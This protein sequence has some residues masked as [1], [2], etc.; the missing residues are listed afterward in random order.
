MDIYIVEFREE[1]GQP[2]EHLER[3]LPV[4]RMSKGEKRIQRQSIYGF[5]L[6]DYVLAEERG[7]TDYECY[8]GEH[9]KPYLTGDDVFFNIS[10]SRS[11]VSV[12]VSDYEVGV[13]IER[14]GR[15]N[16]KLAERVCTERELGRLSLGNDSAD[17]YFTAM[18]VQKEAYAKMTGKGFS[19]GF[20]KIDTLSL[21][22][23]HHRAIEH[24]DYMIGIS[25]STKGIL[26]E[27]N[28]CVV[29]EDELLRHAVKRDREI[30]QSERNK[31]NML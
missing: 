20:D 19:E 15:Y 25:V 30:W 9:G 3:H 1:H 13:D 16:K 27:L 24:E 12:A 14:F 21:D 31:R 26:G 5:F 4:W 18:W 23:V 29:A 6:L 7:F 2:I 11:A 17:R 8:I 22:S 10:H 28:V